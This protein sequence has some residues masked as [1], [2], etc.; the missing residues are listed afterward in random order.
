M[1]RVYARKF[2][3]DEAIRLR[4]EGHSTKA[5]AERLG[6]TW[7]AVHRVVTPG[8]MEAEAVTQAAVAARG[9]CDDC[10]GP[11]NGLSRYR[12]STRCKTCAAIARATS[13]RPDSLQCVMCREWK[14][15]DQF[16]RNR[17]E[18]LA[19]RGRHSTCRA[20]ATIARREYR[21]RNKVPCAGGCGNLVLAPNEQKAYARA[22][23]SRVTGKCR[24]CANRDVAARRRTAV[25]A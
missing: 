6:V 18:S 14:P 21:N 12:G 9:R 20:C 11:M 25:A 2:D 19:R 23:G 7:N 10:G 22:R 4:S 13:V 5:I 24:S 15:D 8:V 1:S 16:P 17:A 3:W